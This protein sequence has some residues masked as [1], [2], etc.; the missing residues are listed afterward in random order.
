MDKMP[1]PEGYDAAAS[2]TILVLE[3][4]VFGEQR[5]ALFGVGAV[6]RKTLFKIRISHFPTTHNTQYVKQVLDLYNKNRFLYIITTSMGK[7]VKRENCAA[8]AI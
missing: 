1:C 3:V 2:A 6:G 4:R 7:A 5:G 8:P